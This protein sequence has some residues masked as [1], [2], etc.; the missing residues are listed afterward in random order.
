MF[1]P[2]KCGHTKRTHLIFTYN[3]KNIL[4]KVDLPYKQDESGL[5]TLYRVIVKPDNTVKVFIDDS[6]VY[7]GS[8]ES[9]WDMLEPKEID[10]PEDKKP[11]DWVDDAM[12]DDPEDKKPADWVEEK[13]IVDKDAKQP[14][15]WDAEEDGEWEAPMIANPDYKGEWSPKRISNPAYKGVWAPKKIANP[16]Y[17]DDKELYMMNKKPMEFVGFDL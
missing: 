10:D 6:E 15:D 9:D 16:K 8:M 13:E 1:G 3:G 11:S 12:I 4:K 7:S 2:D 5:P 14:E 17:V